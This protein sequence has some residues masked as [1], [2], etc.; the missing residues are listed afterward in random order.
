M[1]TRRQCAILALT[2]PFAAS[3]P[4][5]ARAEDA[6]VHIDNFTFEPAKLT[7]KAGTKVK[8]TNRDDIPHTVVSTNR[9]FRSKPMDTDGTFEFTFMAP[10]TYDYFCSLHPH[11]K[12]TVVVE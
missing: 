5:S 12:A 7:V 4:R 11:M 3:V 10:G 1:I 6:E 9:S 2:L 8:W